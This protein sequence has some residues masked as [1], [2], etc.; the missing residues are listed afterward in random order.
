MTATTAV[1]IG[2]SSSRPFSRCASSTCRT[3]LRMVMGT[4]YLQ[5]SIGRPDA[6]SR[7][8]HPTRATSAQPHEATWPI[9]G[10]VLRVAPGLRE[11]QRLNT[12][13]HH[14][15]LDPATHALV[16]LATSGFTGLLRRVSDRT[17]TG[18]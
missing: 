5:G 10:S 16:K 8:R 2:R 7:D 4:G 3:I 1:R 14:R 11:L 18:D 6:S 17:R 12:L 13:A 9:R 15:H